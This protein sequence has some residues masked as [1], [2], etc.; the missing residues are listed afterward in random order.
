MTNQNTDE[1]RQSTVFD[2]L[3]H[4][5]V[6]ATTLSLAHA[7]ILITSS[8]SS[9]DSQLFLFKHL[10][11]LKQQI[12]AFDIEYV[13]PDVSFDFSG[14]ANTFYELRDRGGL[15][16][17]RNLWRFMGGG[18]LPKV[19]ENMLDAKVELDG[20]LR[21]VINEFTNG[22]ASRITTPISETHTSKRG[23]DALAAV[24]QVQQLA[25]KEVPLLRKKL[26]EYLDDLRT[27]ET[28]V[29][30]VQDQVLQNYET[31][32]DTS[33]KDQRANGKTLS[34]KGKGREDEVWDVDMFS[35]W[36]A[37]VFNVRGLGLGDR[38][39][40]SRSRS[41]SRTGSI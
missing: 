16:D 19:V 1:I 4:S 33:T 40:V 24:K 21:T 30:A 23:F 35:E 27:K 29:A 15:F 17:P 20:R 6:H 32:Y 22:F 10:L 31:F 36:C 39:S 41:V 14:V 13:T 38:H 18:L 37:G 26:S 11:I 2:D 9:L 7:S 5:I 12:V 3:A 8:H 34:K 28:L 25:E